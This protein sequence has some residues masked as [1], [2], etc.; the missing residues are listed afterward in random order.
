MKLRIVVLIGFAALL[1][2]CTSGG[3][4][5]IEPP[6]PLVELTS[7]LALE[8]LWT[9]GVDAMEED[10]HL[11]IAP[12]FVS[13][14]LIA[15]SPK[16]LVSAFNVEDGKLLWESDAGIA[17]TGGPGAGDDIVVLGSSEGL[18]AALSETDG[19]LRWRSQ[20]SSE[21]L[22]APL[23]GQG[24]V[25]VRTVDGKVFGLNS[26]T[27][28]RL[29]VYERSVPPLSLRGASAPIRKGDVLFA[30]F[31][32]G[33]L[34]AL[35]ALTGK[36]LWEIAAIQPKGRT[37]LE[38]M[39]DIDANLGIQGYF[40]YAAAYQGH[41]LAVDT[42]TGERIW[43]RETSSHAGLSVDARAV[44]VS[45]AQSH[46]WAFDRYSGATLWKQSKLQG[47][48]ITAPVNFD[49][50]LVVG[51]FEGYLHWLRREDGQFAERYSVGARIPVPPLAINGTLIAYN[52]DG[53]ITAIRENKER[54]QRYKQMTNDQ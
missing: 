35:E 43:S 46:I 39:A 20:V 21:I 3:D 16:G 41:T 48:D 47:R 49:E 51:D 31:D 4:E 27:G 52:V 22:A 1:N 45:D 30:G 38:R 10:S 23:V 32:N 15:A 5:I 26:E 29:W 50:Y 37:E 13:D 36:P 28:K 14:K 2:A 12:V 18:L 24:L 34:A 54:T 25:C 42:D 44:Y 17:V 11:K 40:L 33:K 6:A 53:K 8:T 9:V 19:S 7:T